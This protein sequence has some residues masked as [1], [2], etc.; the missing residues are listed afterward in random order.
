MPMSSSTIDDAD[1][2]RGRR[3]YAAASNTWP[4]GFGRMPRRRQARA[5][6]RRPPAPS[7]PRARSPPRRRGAD[8]ADAAGGSR[9]R[10]RPLAT[11]DALSSRRRPAAN[12]SR[13]L[14]CS[15]RR[16]PTSA[17]RCAA[18]RLSRTTVCLRD[19]SG[20]PKPPGS[21]M[22]RGADDDA[23][24]RGNRLRAARLRATTAAARPRAPW[25][26][27]RC[28]RRASC[29]RAITD[30]SSPRRQARRP[31]ACAQ[32]VGDVAVFVARPRSSLRSKSGRRSS[33]PS[34]MPC[35]DSTAVPCA[36]V[37]SP[38][39]RA[40]RALQPQPRRR[41]SSPQSTSGASTIS[42]RAARAGGGASPRA[43]APPGI[44]RRSGSGRA[45]SSD[46]AFSITR[47]DR[48]ESRAACCDGGWIGC[49]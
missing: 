4:R 47:R 37:G 32:E 11:A 30:V 5:R 3:L 6:A 9:L 26:A 19:S 36:W 25:S 33:S 48:P 2:R 24:R 23:A 20:V 7:P 38:R 44:P 34:T 28:R 41:R 45:G 35:V 12:A 14:R 49:A 42:R 43:S 22:R 16:A 21:V 10:A 29:A 17:T 27:S 39:S 8:C 15:A 13:L 46:S 31:I 18:T 40:R 1:S